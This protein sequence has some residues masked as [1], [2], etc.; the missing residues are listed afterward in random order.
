[1]RTGE[2]DDQSKTRS[3]PAPERILDA[4]DELRRLEKDQRRET[5]ST[6]GSHHLTEDVTKKSHDI[7]EMA[8]R[9]EAVADQTETTDESIEQVEGREPN[10]T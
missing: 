5:I 4:I 8:D 7:F 6:P 3:R 1:L 10:Q 2:C 9:Q